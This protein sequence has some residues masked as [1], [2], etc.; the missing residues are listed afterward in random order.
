MNASNVSLAIPDS[1]YPPAG[2]VVATHNEWTRGN[3]PKMIASFKAA[4]LQMHDI[5]F[6][7]N[8]ITRQG[9]D[10]GQRLNRP[11][12]RNRGIA[13]DV[14]DGVLQRLEEIVYVQPTAVFLEI[15]INDLFN[16]TLSPARTADNIIKIVHTLHQ[17]SPRT[18][19]FVQTIFPTD[20]PGMVSRIQETNDR[21][22]HHPYRQ[23][24]TLIDTHALFADEQD[25]MKKEFT[26]DGVHLT[27]KGY[28]V[29]VDCLKKY[30]R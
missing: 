20:K 26:R 12:I 17:R 9:G 10:W 16:D 14:T 2:Q 28:Q 1:L 13:G 18:K 7:G 27:E 24:F 29:W 4:P 22:R 30:F 19:I 3:Y 5:V 11:A 21:V 23:L 8:S 15:G 6:L 25:L